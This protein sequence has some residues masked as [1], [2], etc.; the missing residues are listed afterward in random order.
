MKKKALT[1]RSRRQRSKVWLLDDIGACRETFDVGESI[2][3][4]A[5]GLL[6]TT[7]Y[8]I[9]MR[10]EEKRTELLARLMTDRYGSLPPTVLLPYVG[11]ADSEHA[12]QGGFR[13][14][15]EAE[16]KI[17]GRTFEVRARPAKGRAAATVKFIVPK[18][19]TKP[20]LYSCE[21]KGRLQT[22]FEVGE[23]DMRVALRNFRRGCVKI[24]VVPRQF[25]WQPG[26]P[27]EPVLD[28]NGAPLIITLRNESR[29]ITV[30]SIWARDRVRPGSYQFIARPYRPGWYNAGDMVL[31]PD[32]IVSSRLISSLVVRQDIFKV[33]AIKGGCV[34]TPELA[35]RPLN[36][37]PYFR[38]T[39]NFPKGTDVYAALDPAGLPAGVVSQKAAIYV[40]KHKEQA[41]WQASK[42][43]YDIT[44]PAG[45]ANPKIVPIIPCCINWNET[46]VWPN[47]QVSGKYDI[48]VDFGNNS[49]TPALFATDGKFDCDIAAPIDMIDGYIRV[50]FHVTE[51]PSLTGPYAGK[52]GR[53]EYNQTAVEV[54][55]TDSGPTPTQWLQRKAVVRYPAQYSG[56]D[57]PFPTGSGTFP[58]VVIMHGQ[59][60]MQTSYLGY[61]YLLDHLAS[62]GLIAMSIYAPVGSMIE[63]RA[64]AIIEHLKIMSQ[65]NSNPGLFQGHVDLTEIGIMGHSRGGEAVIRAAQINTSELLNWKLKAG[66]SLAATDFNHYGDPGIPLLVIYGSNDGDVAGWWGTPP[67][68]SHTGFD[69]YDESGLPRSHVFVYGATHDRFNSEWASTETSTELLFQPGSDISSWGAIHKS[70]LSKLISQTAHQNVAKGYVT[71]YYQMHLQGKNEQNE[72]FTGELKPTLASTVEIHNSNQEPGGLTVDDFEQLPHDATKNSMGEMVTATT[73]VSPPS[74]NA[75]RTLDNHSPHQTCGGRIV[76]NNTAGTYQSNIKPNKK[77]VSKYKVLSFRVTQKYGSSYNLANQ[78]QDLYVRLTGA[79]NTRAIRVGAFTQVPYPYERGVTSLIKSALKTVRIPLSAYIVKVPNADIMDL[80]QIESVSFEFNAKP[81]GEIEVD[82]IEFGY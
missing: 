63:V 69:I 70:D 14:H 59:S 27:I 72:Y 37:R 7:V 13:T 40:I 41:D 28:S 31:L 26:D 42:S 54:P 68:A 74:E 22:G 71:A 57:A 73:L 38:F 76:W 45:T 32:D 52:I 3:I 77:D 20:Q 49:A 23:E 39:N 79:G 4:S 18:R 12:E 25:D 80:K 81:S 35:G 8:E 17:G 29:R 58:L 56:V 51:D 60:S 47:P 66:I 2:Y 11:L 6:P 44:G 67:A 15:D 55:S 75:M 65:K 30:V 34:S 19:S 64:R 36:S 78:L 10:P 82:E 24:F 53:H 46:L 9:D 16:R 62:H 43:L 33:K 61:N 50:G 5:Q 48:V 21:E 1:R